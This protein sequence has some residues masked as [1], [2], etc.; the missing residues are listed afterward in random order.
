LWL[1][2]NKFK[3]K[4]KI[5][6]SESNTKIPPFLMKKNKNERSAEQIEKELKK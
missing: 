4:L 6:N 5:K 1:K 3:I 2:D